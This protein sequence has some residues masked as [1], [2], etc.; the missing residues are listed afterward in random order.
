MP[1]LILALLSLLLLGDRMGS[2]LCISAWSGT[3][4]L[5]LASAYVPAR[6]DPRGTLLICTLL[7]IG[8]LAISPLLIIMLKDPGTSLGLPLL[9]AAITGP[10]LVAA[11]YLYRAMSNFSASERRFAGLICVLV[12]GLPGLFYLIKPSPS[13]QI[14]HATAQTDEITLIIERDTPKQSTTMG[15]S[16]ISKLPYTAIHYENRTYKPQPAQSRVSFPRKGASS[17]YVV[18]ERIQ[19][20]PHSSEWPDQVTWTVH[21]QQT[22]QLMAEREL[23]RR[24]T[25]EWSKDTPS[26]W[27]GDH[28]AD[29]IRG[30][31]KPAS[32]ARSRHGYPHSDFRLE[33]APAKDVITLT[34]IENR[35]VGCAAGIELIDDKPH[36]YM[37]SA[38]PDWRFESHFRISQVFCIDSD[39]YVIS[40][41]LAQDIYIDH[42][43]HQGNLKGQFSTSAPRGLHH[44]GIRLRHI[45][46]F[47]AD[48]DELHLQLAFLKDMPNVGSPA[49]ASRQ[50]IIHIARSPGAVAQ[51]TSSD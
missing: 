27:Q 24:G 41:L 18:K 9:S 17:R 26:G 39:I 4:G 30:V 21:D 1:A 8:L 19:V 25:S 22:G 36:T 2:L 42:L 49:L 34:A 16:Y 13:E 29:F 44:D 47:H 23:W 51:L 28:A 7:L 12:V 20:N 10:V 40:Q 33:E 50:V 38:D 37:K 35:V 14:I 6:Y 32:P 43:D 3:I 46:S 15:L 45:S 11:H 5:I 31:L 48:K